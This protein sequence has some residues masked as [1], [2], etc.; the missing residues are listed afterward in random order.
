MNMVTKVRILKNPV[1]EILKIAGK[2]RF[3]FIQGGENISFGL[4]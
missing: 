2:S 4:T 3:Q 1:T